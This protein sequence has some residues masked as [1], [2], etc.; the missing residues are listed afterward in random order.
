VVQQVAGVLGPGVGGEVPPRADDRRA[1]V[2]GDAHGHHVLLDELADLDAGVEAG[3]DEVDAAVVGGDVENDLRVVA[4]EP[5]ELRDERD[6]RGTA[7]QEQAH[8]A[9][10]P[11]AEARHLLDR[12]VDVVECRLPPGEELL[13]CVGR[14]HAARGTRQQPDPHALFQAPM[15]WLRADGDT[16]R[17][18]AARVKLRSSA[19][20]TKAARAPSS[21]RSIPEWYSQRLCDFSV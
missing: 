14:S 7:R 1:E 6:H 17:R 10:R 21:S 4:R 15:A 11:V 18:F 13:S 16:P 12:L 2:L 8:A 3:G 20:A 19:T 9:G 5:R